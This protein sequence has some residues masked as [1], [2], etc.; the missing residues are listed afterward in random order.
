MLAHPFLSMIVWV[1]AQLV[2]GLVGYRQGRKDEE[3]RWLREVEKFRK[4][5]WGR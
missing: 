3:L 2:C 1:S 4:T 5:G